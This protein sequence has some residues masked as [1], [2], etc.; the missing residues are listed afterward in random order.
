MP[1][2]TA[3]LMDCLVMCNVSLTS[4]TSDH[5]LEMYPVLEAALARRDGPVLRDHLLALDRDM[6]LIRPPNLWV[7]ISEYGVTTVEDAM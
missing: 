4:L 3:M 1:V 2:L 6:D 5:R 7:L